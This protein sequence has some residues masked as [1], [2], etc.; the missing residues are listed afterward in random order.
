MPPSCVQLRGAAQLDRLSVGLRPWATPFTLHVVI[1]PIGISHSTPNTGMLLGFQSGKMNSFAKE[2]K[3]TPVEGDLWPPF[4]CMKHLVPHSCYLPKINRRTFSKHINVSGYVYAFLNVDPSKLIREHGAILH[5]MCKC[6]WVCVCM[7][8][9]YSFL[10]IEQRGMSVG[11]PTKGKKKWM[12][13]FPETAVS[14][15]PLKLEG[16]RGWHQR[17][18]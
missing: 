18:D 5:Y 8:Q 16:G 12:L 3:Y 9:S 6:A 7:Y 11:F 14:L 17:E 10:F 4:Q 15:D 2:S 13:V 1:W